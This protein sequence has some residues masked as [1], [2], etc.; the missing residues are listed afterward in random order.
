MTNHPPQPG[1]EDH[2]SL[3]ERLR[4][5]REQVQGRR[6]T[7]DSRPLLEKL[8]ELRARVMLRLQQVR[9]PAPQ[10][11]V[12][13]I[14]QNAYFGG[15]PGNIPLQT[16]PLPTAP[17]PMPTAAVEGVETPVFSSLDFSRLDPEKSCLMDSSQAV[18]MTVKELQKIRENAVV[19]ICELLNLSSLRELPAFGESYGLREWLVNE[20]FLEGRVNAAKSRLDLLTGNVLVL[21]KA[22]ETGILQR[23]GHKLAFGTGQ[24]L[25]FYM[26]PGSDS[27]SVIAYRQREQGPLEPLNPQY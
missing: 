8:T 2:R 15:M 12:F 9:Q 17:A 1:P 21:Q 13:Y 27:M 25:V 6:G 20:G 11:Q 4:D 10:Q 5:L 19:R 3:E 26:K 22:L 14:G 16:G 18:P 24:S 23:Q 7:E